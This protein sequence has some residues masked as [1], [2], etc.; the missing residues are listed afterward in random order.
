ML[1]LFYRYWH[2]QVRF[3]KEDQV[4]NPEFKGRPSPYLNQFDDLCIDIATTAA[5]INETLDLVLCVDDEDCL[6]APYYICE[7][8]EF[9]YLSGSGSDAL[10]SSSGSGSGS[11]S[12]VDDGMRDMEDGDEEEEEDIT[13]P[14]I[15]DIPQ[16]DYRHDNN[17]TQFNDTTE[18]EEDDGGYIVWDIDGSLNSENI[19]TTTIATTAISTTATYYSTSTFTP[20]PTP[21]IIDDLTGKPDIGIDDDDFTE[22]P[23]NELTS[24][25]SPEINVTSSTTQLETTVTLLLL[26]TMTFFCL[27][28]A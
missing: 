16:E 21:A 22:K 25:P 27:L 11:G 5:E 14:S 10:L 18:E 1:T 12:N 13:T 28:L 20:T 15:D 19:T 3:T 8:D 9:E 2:S 23:D 4:D 26:A 6:V 24:K 7:P 17:S